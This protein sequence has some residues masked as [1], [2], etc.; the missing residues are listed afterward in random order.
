MGPHTRLIAV[1]VLCS[2]CGGGG[3]ASPTAPTPISPQKTITSFSTSASKTTLAIGQQATLTATAVYS[4]GTSAQIPQIDTTGVEWVSNDVSVARIE[5]G[6]NPSDGWNQV[7]AKA[8]GTTTIT[9]TYGEQT[10]SVSI[11]V[12]QTGTVVGWIRNLLQE[13]WIENAVVRIGNTAAV[14]SDA[15]GRFAVAVE[16]TGIFPVVIQ[17]NGFHTSE[18]EIEV[19]SSLTIARR[20]LLT[21]NTDYFDLVFFDHVFRNKGTRGTRRWA[22]TPTVEIWTK[23]MKCVETDDNGKHCRKFEA[24]DIAAPSEFETT[25]RSV[26]GSDIPSLT[27]DVISGISVTTKDHAAGTILERDSCGQPNKIKVAYMTAGTT[28][29]SGRYSYAASCSYSSGEMVGSEVHMA[30]TDDVGTYRHELAHTLGWSHPDGYDSIPRPSVMNLDAIITAWDT[31]HGKVLYRR[32]AGSTSPDKDPSGKTINDLQ[33]LPWTSSM[34]PKLH[35]N[36]PALASGRG[37]FRGPLI[38]WIEN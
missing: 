27:D 17:A 33:A 30:W 14:R 18:S 20:N 4:D 11:T 21:T 7:R 10:A 19:Q 25:I 2:A 9:A 35:Q 23:E 32:A 12:T 38:A 36:R 37:R 24:T 31:K 8:S 13:G 29:F 28:D 3:G 22:T 16:Q 1:A 26:V 5:P 15:N 34:R 6:Q